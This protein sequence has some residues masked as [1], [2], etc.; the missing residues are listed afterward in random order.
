MADHACEAPKP[1]R[2]DKSALTHSQKPR[3]EVLFSSLGNITNAISPPKRATIPMKRSSPETSFESSKR[4]R[5]EAPLGRSGNRCSSVILISISDQ[6]AN[7]PAGIDS[8]A[9]EGH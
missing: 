2:Q 3:S 8:G 5:K 1:F 9:S 7:Q 4:P 6:H